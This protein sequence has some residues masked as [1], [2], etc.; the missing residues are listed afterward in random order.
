MLGY[1]I[2]ESVDVFPWFFENAYEWSTL[3]VMLQ[4]VGWQA[5]QY[6]HE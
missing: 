1:F 2:V 4:I 5:Q 6:Q 3:K